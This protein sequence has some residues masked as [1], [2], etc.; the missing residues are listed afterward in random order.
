MLKSKLSP[1]NDTV[2]LRELNPSIKRCIK[3]FCKFYCLMKLFSHKMCVIIANILFFIG[4]Y[5]LNIQKTVSF[6]V[7]KSSQSISHFSTSDLNLLL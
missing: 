4:A 7:L 2:A 6:K 3:F 5:L 1:R